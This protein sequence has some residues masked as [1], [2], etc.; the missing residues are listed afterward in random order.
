MYVGVEYMIRS[1]KMAVLTFSIQPW[2]DQCLLHPHPTHMT[3]L[4]MYL[5]QVPADD[6]CNFS[7][8]DSLS[9]G[10]LRVPICWFS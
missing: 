6:W 5:H 3:D 9:K 7:H 1:P 2:L 4:P 10:W 8:Q